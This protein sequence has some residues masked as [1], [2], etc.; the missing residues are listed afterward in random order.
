MAFKENEKEGIEKG[1]NKKNADPAT[2]GNITNYI[3]VFH[4]FIVGQY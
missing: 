2:Q 3:N 1:A 4:I